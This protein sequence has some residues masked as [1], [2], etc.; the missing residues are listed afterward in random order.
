MRTT[1]NPRTWI[2]FFPP[3]L[4][5]GIQQRMIEER[6][7]KICMDP[8]QKSKKKKSF[9]PALLARL[10]RT[11]SL[12]DRPVLFLSCFSAMEIAAA[13]LSRCLFDGDAATHRI[14]CCLSLQQGS[15]KFISFHREVITEKKQIVWIIQTRVILENIIG[16]FT[17]SLGGFAPLLQVHLIYSKNAKVYHSYTTTLRRHDINMRWDANMLLTSAFSRKQYILWVEWMMNEN[18]NIECLAS[19]LLR[20]SWFSSL[21][22]AMHAPC[23]DWREPRQAWQGLP[24]HWLAFLG[25]NNVAVCVCVSIHFIHKSLS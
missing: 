10:Q 25:S 5:S 9:L 4:S 16:H 17:R 15:S 24:Y 14:S 22:I 21:P 12:T 8:S 6:G 23:A 11:C 19:W 1:Q 18:Q 2:I 3:S 13:P 7:T 20:W